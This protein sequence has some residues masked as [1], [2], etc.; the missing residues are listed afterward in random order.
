MGLK[1][2]GATSGSIEL[3]VPAAI[4]SDLSVTLPATAG[5]IIVADTNGD[6]VFSRTGSGGSSGSAQ[7]VGYQ[8]GDWTPDLAVGTANVDSTSWTRI[9][10]R[11]T[12]SGRLTAFSDTT[13]TATIEIL[14][15]SFPYSPVVPS[16]TVCIGACF[17]SNIGRQPTLVSQA[18]TGRAR[19]CS[20]AANNSS[21]ILTARHIDIGTGPSLPFTFSYLTEDT[22]WTP[23]SGASVS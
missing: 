5:E 1:L 22:T 11:V 3:D 7:L 15:D 18:T 23:N 2:N 19:F 4:G 12:V 16:F 8:Q 20:S 9:G 14:P 13:S 17:A 10:N 21:N 6:A